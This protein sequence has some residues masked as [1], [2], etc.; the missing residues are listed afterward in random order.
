MIRVYELG[1]SHFGR[2]LPLLKAYKEDIQDPPLDDECE[3]KI[4]EAI[5]SSKITFFVA[6]E[7]G[8]LVGMYSD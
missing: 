8:Q 5:R 4:R 1:E 2:L 7:V 3:N 6:E